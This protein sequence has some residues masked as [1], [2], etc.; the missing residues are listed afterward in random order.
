[1]PTCSIMPT[2]TTR[3]KRPRALGSRVRRNSTRSATPASSRALARDG[4]LLRRDVD[5]GDLAP[6]A[7][8]RWTA[9]EPQPEPISATVIPGVRRSL[10]RSAR[11]CPAGPARA[12]SVSMFEERAGIVQPLVEEETVHLRRQV[13]VMPRVA[14]GDA[15]CG[16]ACCQRFTAAASAAV[17][18]ASRVRRARTG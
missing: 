9:S 10:G 11:A 7:L 17:S 4:D 6:G 14:G 2:E 3:S 16:F 13:V 18:S 8:A 1:M 15:R 5:R 12:V